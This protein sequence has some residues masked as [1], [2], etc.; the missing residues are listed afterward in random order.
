M[1]WARPLL[2]ADI[3]LKSTSGGALLHQ[4]QTSGPRARQ[5][6]QRQR[7]D[8][9]RLTR[10]ARDGSRRIGDPGSTLRAPGPAPGAAKN[11]EFRQSGRLRAALI[12]H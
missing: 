8:G 6:L 4:R 11:Q 2:T 10:P 7:D 12:P 9:R 5:G 1:T 3:L